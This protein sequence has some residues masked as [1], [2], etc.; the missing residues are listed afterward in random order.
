[1]DK[2]DRQEK[3]KREFIDA[4]K[5]IIKEENVESVSARKIAAITGYSYATLYNY[6]KDID[7]L[8]AYVAVDFLEESYDYMIKGLERNDD[9]IEKI[10][11][12]SKRYFTYMYNHP[13]VF[14]VVFIN[15][16]GQE[17]EDI[18]HKLVPKVTILLK[19]LIDDIDDQTLPVSKDLTYEFISSSIHAKLMFSIFKRSPLTL[20]QNLFFIDKELKEIL[21]EK[22]WKKDY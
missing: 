9:P 14:K 22:K 5:K 2:K 19:Q 3:I 18:S 21:G 10:I 12:C 8:F 13:S 16:F 6:Y 4:A 17:I 7:T 1:M 20:A 15:N 11:I